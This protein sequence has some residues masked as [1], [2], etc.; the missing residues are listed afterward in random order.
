MQFIIT[1]M[2]GT[3]APAVARQ[4]ER[5]GHAAI[6][7]DRAQVA[8]DD[9]AAVQRFI[10]EQQPDGV[11]H[12][13]TGSPDWAASIAR[14]CA[15]T[16]IKLVHTGSVSVF[17]PHQAGPFAVTTPPEA[18]DDYGAYKRECERRIAQAN[19]QA[20]IARLGWQIGSAPGGNHML[21]FL[22]RTVAETGQIEAS[23]AWFPACAFLDDTAAGL[24]QL[25]LDYPA[26]LY[27]LDGNP[28][29]SFFEIVGALN[30]LHGNA[31]TVIPS[32]TPD[33]NN[34]MLDERIQIQPIT[35]RF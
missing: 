9:D 19:P 14:C 22:S 8:P 12:I 21:D 34:R 16:G 10:R 17:G 15:E 24:V 27:Q 1:G 31:W 33:Q 32:A 28:G 5:R 3:V 26:G 29:L 6:A 25:M 35:A 7:W 18:S 4:L 30:R 20:I 23:A 2:N 13:A 11:F